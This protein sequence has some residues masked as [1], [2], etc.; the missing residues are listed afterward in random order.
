MDIPKTKV[1]S[2]ESKE[3]LNISR[4]RTFMADPKAEVMVWHSF[5]EL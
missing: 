3:F 1:S 4:I 5:A 2:D